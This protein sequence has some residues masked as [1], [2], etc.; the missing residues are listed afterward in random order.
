MYQRIMVAIDDSF[1]TSRVLATAI[2]MAKLS[3]ASLAICHAVDETLFAQK[4]GEIMLSHSVTA[5]ESTLRGE[6]QAFLDQAAEV[7]RGAGVAVETRLI[8]SEAKQ[9][10]DM[11]A[12]AAEKWQADLLVVGSNGK[13]G[14]DRF[15]VGSVASRLVQKARTS[16]LL[17]RAP[18]A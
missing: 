7:A 2:E 17:V 3:G 16:L 8:A 14:L 18:G 13:R 12:E 9:I 4:M 1:A 5:I 10:A 6:A 15:F 11:L